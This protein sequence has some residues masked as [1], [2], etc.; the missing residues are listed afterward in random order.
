MSQRISW[1][2]NY[3]KDIKDITT[4]LWLL[5]ILFYM[6]LNKPTLPWEASRA[7]SVKQNRK[8]SSYYLLLDGVVQAV[9]DTYKQNNSFMRE[10][11]ERMK[12]YDVVLVLLILTSLVPQR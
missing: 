8:S 2:P 9:D 3:R 11:V 1:C 6:F 4:T 10:M 12:S 7:K 5:Y